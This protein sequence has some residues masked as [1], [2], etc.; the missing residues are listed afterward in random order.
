MRRRERGLGIQKLIVCGA[1]CASLTKQLA[2]VVALRHVVFDYCSCVCSQLGFAQMICQQQDTWCE[3]GCKQ[4]VN[5]MIILP[6]FYEQFLIVLHI[7][8]QY[9]RKSYSTIYI[10]TKEEWVGLSCNYLKL[11]V[12][13]VSSI[14]KILGFL[15]NL[16]S[17]QCIPAL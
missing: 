6:V 10:S 3:H 5:K 11:K 9:L 14:D 4:T 17:K 7:L 2:W 1:V 15:N 12:Q 8:R 16:Q 13:I